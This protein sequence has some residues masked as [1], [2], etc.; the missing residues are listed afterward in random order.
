M[1]GGVTGE[2]NGVSFGG[3]ENVLKLIVMVDTQLYRYKIIE[4]Y[5]LNGQIGWYINYILIK[6][7]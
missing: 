4:L 2:E 3:N 6:F 7:F 1:R 5:S